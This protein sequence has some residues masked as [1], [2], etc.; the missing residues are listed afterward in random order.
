MQKHAP[1][2]TS[3]SLLRL[4]CTHP[5]LT[6]NPP[7]QYRGLRQHVVRVLAQNLHQGDDPAPVLVRDARMNSCTGLGWGVARLETMTLE[8]M[9]TPTKQFRV[10]HTNREGL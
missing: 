2:P 10:L 4:S 5:R 1:I 8:H 3:T 7:T 6:N 9:Q